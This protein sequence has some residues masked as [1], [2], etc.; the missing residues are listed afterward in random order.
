M[1]RRRRAVLTVR[2][3][4]A[5]LR[6][7][8]FRATNT[9]PRSSRKTV[10]RAQVD[11]AQQRRLFNWSSLRAGSV[12]RKAFDTR[13]RLPFGMFGT[14]TLLVLQ[15]VLLTSKDVLWIRLLPARVE[16]RPHDF[17]NCTCVRPDLFNAR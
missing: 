3:K 14:E 7:V 17:A 13:M 16:T 2:E 12:H 6:G 8:S 1:P 9:T 4:E 5:L 15:D 11:C 10:D